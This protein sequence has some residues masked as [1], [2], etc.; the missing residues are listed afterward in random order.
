MR[1]VA[2]LLLVM[3]LSLGLLMPRVSV[4][5]AALTGAEHVVFC[6]GSSLVVL[7]LDDEGSP[8]QVSHEDPCGLSPVDL[9]ILPP[10]LAAA[11]LP[12]TLHL[13]RRRMAL[14]TRLAPAK[15]HKPRAPPRIGRFCPTR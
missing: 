9:P 12:K 13:T 5:L 7:T 14:V 2:R 1:F 11:P 8:E 6:D 3:I 10:A 15:R 4:M